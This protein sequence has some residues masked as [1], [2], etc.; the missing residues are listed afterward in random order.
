MKSK[1]IERRENLKQKNQISG[2]Q[3]LENKEIEKKKIKN[4]KIENTTCQIKELEP[5]NQS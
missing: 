5:T 4:K 1:H 2:E 3:K